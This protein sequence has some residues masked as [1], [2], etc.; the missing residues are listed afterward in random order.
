MHY[1]YLT[2]GIYLDQ[3]KRWHGHFPSEQLLVLKSETMYADPAATLK[4]VESFLGIAHYDFPKLAPFNAG[5]YSDMNP[6]TRKRLEDFFQPHNE[7]LS[8]YLGDEYSWT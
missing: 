2:K 1:S 4:R 6:E 5:A 8:E 7:Q 3:I